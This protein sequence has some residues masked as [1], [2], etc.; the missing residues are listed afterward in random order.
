MKNR[1]SLVVAL[2]V[3]TGCGEG[4]SPYRVVGELTSDRIELTA[5]TNEPITSIEVSE[6]EPV[7]AGQVLVAQDPRRAAARLSEAE[8]ALAQAQARLDELVRGPRRELIEGARANV[9]G[10]AQEKLAEI[11]AA[12]SERGLKV[13]TK[14][15][16]GYPPEVIVDEAAAIGADLIAMGTHGRT[17]LAH[18]FLGSTAERVVQ[19]A[20]CPVLTLRRHH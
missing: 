13:E 19:H 9:E 1:L 6:G 7:A 12:L 11:A 18:L 3:L 14:A 20:G 2:A 10:A 17:G 8:A 4:D 15:I 5:E 16:E